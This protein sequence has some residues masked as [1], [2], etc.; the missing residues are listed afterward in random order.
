MATIIDKT[1]PVLCGHG[2]IFR[3]QVVDNDS[4]YDNDVVLDCRDE[5]PK[6]IDKSVSVTEREGVYRV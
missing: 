2:D 3:C 1:F 5:C 4:G 6:S